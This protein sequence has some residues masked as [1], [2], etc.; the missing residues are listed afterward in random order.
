MHSTLVILVA[1]HLLGV[2]VLR[3]LSAAAQRPSV[4]A[5]LTQAG[6]VAAAMVVLMGGWCTRLVI[7]VAVAH[8]LAGLVRWFV[9][10]GTMWTEIGRFTIDQTV[11]VAAAVAL[12][13][14]YQHAAAEGVW[15]REWPPEL[16]RW[17]MIALTFLC[18]AIVCVVVGGEV[19]GILTPPLLREIKDAQQAAARRANPDGEGRYVILNESDLDGLRRGGRYIGWL[20]RSLV[21]IL[22][23]MNQVNAVGFVV[24]AKS[25]LRYGD[26]RDSH[27]RR[28]TEYVIIG[29]FLSFGWA[30]LTAVLTRKAID[31]W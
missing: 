11:R 19:I 3:P 16:Q 20:E 22:V 1:A 28:V 18:G 24:T 15:L 9:M 23:L 26:I 27:Q 17:Y 2:F 5:V 14:M 10:Q 7:A 31:L 12:A 21:L 25:I 6:I 13:V 29:T 30:I 4:A 8:A